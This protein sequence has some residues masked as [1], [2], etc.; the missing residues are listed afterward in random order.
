M[1]ENAVT[2]PWYGQLVAKYLGVQMFICCR[3]PKRIFVVF[4]ADLQ[5]VALMPVQNLDSRSTRFQEIIE[6]NIQKFKTF[7]SSKHPKAQNIQKSKT[8]K[9][10][11]H[12][13]V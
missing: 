1:L 2:F 4:C 8:F 12:S 7:K 11:K 5:K 10:P 3:E 6:G 9:S 13:K